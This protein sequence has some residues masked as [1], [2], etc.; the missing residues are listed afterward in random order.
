MES[1]TTVSHKC[2]SDFH[3]VFF[4]G[5]KISFFQNLV[6]ELSSAT[7]LQAISP[8]GLTNSK[9]PS[10]RLLARVYLTLGSWQWVLSPGLDEETI[11]GSP[12]LLVHTAEISWAII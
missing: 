11:K 2:P 8:I 7:N 12:Y 9:S 5:A 6:V 3:A 10:A 4:T 1:C